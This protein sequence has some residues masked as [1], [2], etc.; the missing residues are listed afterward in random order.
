MC[1]GI[2]HSTTGIEVA[3][4]DDGRVQSVFQ[5]DRRELD[6]CESVLG[7]PVGDVPSGREPHQEITQS[8]DG[9]GQTR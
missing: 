2:E 7:N 6:A 4:Q 5:I 8:L 3:S 1:V 9:S